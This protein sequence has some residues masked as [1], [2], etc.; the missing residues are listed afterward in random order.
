MPVETKQCQNCVQAF[1]IEPEDFL[2]YEKIHVPPPTWCPECRM[3]R[4]MVWRNERALYKRNCELCKKD[5][6]S[7]Y[8]TSVEFP[9]YCHDCWWSDKWSP[10]DY[11]ADYNPSENFL[12]QLKKLL[13]RTPHAALQSQNAVN[14]P[15]VNVTLNIKDSYLVFGG[16]D[17][18]N[19]YYS[20]QNAWAKDS[21]EIS[22]CDKV[23]LCY[24]TVQCDH[25]SNLFFSGHS[26]GCSYSSFLLDCRNCQDCFLCVGLRNKQYCF[27][28]TQYSKEEYTRLVSELEPGGFKNLMKAKEEFKK[29]ILTSLS[30]FARFRNAINSTGDDLTNVKKLKNCY[31]SREAEN[32]AHSLFAVDSIKDS[33]DVTFAGIKAELLYEMHSTPQSSRSYFNYLVWSSNETQYSQD[34]YSS[35]DLF[36]C[37]GLRN[38]SYCILNKQYTKEEYEKL[39]PRI[40]EHMNSMPYIDKKGRVYKYGE[41]FPPELSPFSYNE[42][43]AQEYFPLTKEETESKGYR[44]KDPEPRNYEITLK[45]EAIPDH[46]KDVK[47]SILNEIIGC[48]HEQKCNEQCT[49]AFRIISQELEF[50]KKMNL[51]LPRL[52]PNCRHYQRIKQRNPLKLWQRKCTCAG[53]QSENGIYQNSASHRHGTTH[54]P[55]EFETSYAPERPEIVYCED[56]YQSEVV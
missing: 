39:V 31:A 9:V 45:T 50:Y 24:E 54:C 41:F 22:F 30:R 37:V 26:S 14:S 5:V 8:P 46:I 40:I 48:A 19:L 18:E 35:S 4:R 49:Q 53:I 21:F 33:Y 34:C 2:F 42:T 17:N 10:F 36:V 51:P 11:A 38:K 13:F 55:E 15:Y 7:M 43:I 25:S 29:L 52:C 44:W 20:N 27:L 47:E 32:C 23:E 6:I 3:V 28:N 56:C 1:Q 16:H 12:E